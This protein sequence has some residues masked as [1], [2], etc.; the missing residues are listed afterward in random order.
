M[1]E[2]IMF[3]THKHLEA[4]I[5][6]QSHNITRRVKEQIAGF[7]FADDAKQVVFEQDIADEILE[8]LRERYDCSYYEYWDL[9]DWVRDLQHEVID[10]FRECV[11]LI[12]F[13][14]HYFDGSQVDFAKFIGKPKQ[15]ITEMLK[16][17]Y[18]VVDGSVYSKRF[19]LPD[20][21]G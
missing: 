8:D 18:I 16:A 14:D 7:Q 11:D 13:I 17:G 3:I 21:A 20:R 4:F 9:I 19:E 6:D 1:G 5:N 15:R 2:A 10:G 12:D